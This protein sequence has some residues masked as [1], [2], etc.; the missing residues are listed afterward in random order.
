MA[1]AEE[2]RHAEAGLRQ[3][4]LRVLRQVG[5]R[6]IAAEGGQEVAPLCLVAA[7]QAEG[8]ERRGDEVDRA[9]RPGVD[10]PP[11]QQPRV[12]QEERHLDRRVVDEEGVGLLAVLAQAL[13]VIG[14]HHDQGVVE[15]ALVA[16]LVEHLPHR[17]VQHRDLGVVDG[18][19][20]QPL[21]GRRG[22]GLV[23]VEEVHP[24]EEGAA[25]PLLRPALEPAH[26]PRRR[27]RTGARA[28]EEELRLV[29]RPQVVV[30]AVEALA[31]VVAAVEDQRR[32][33]RLG[34]VAGPLQALGQGD[35]VVAQGKGAVVAHPV[36]RRIE[37]GQD[38][39]VRGEGDGRGA[40][41]I[42]AAHPLGRQA[43]DRRRPR[44]LEAVATEAVGAGGV[45]GD[46]EE[47]RPRAASAARGGG[48]RERRERDGQEETAGPAPRRARRRGDDRWVPLH[49]R[50][51]P[52][53]VRRR[54]AP[55]PDSP[56][57]L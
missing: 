43:V 20:A 38:R 9:H 51:S 11:R 2:R 10:L 45:E 29:L 4:R 32:D 50:A 7:R 19:R 17:P 44:E 3:E 22:V 34:A 54:R 35:R 53:I 13:A 41:R 40:H 42:G 24:E 37:A 14:G 36:G 28:D 25:R 8:G 39:R 16:Q 23:G 52:R 6:L 5:R 31:Q 48:E 55:A 18:R 26:R 47:V 30:I 46:E 1:D 49:G 12:A 15:L 21:G 33:D 56:A 57:R 27:L